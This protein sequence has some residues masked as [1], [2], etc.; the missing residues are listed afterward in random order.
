MKVSRKLWLGLLAGVATFDGERHSIRA[1]ATETQH[2][3][4]HGRRYWLHAAAYLS[5]RF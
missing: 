4:H 2:R 1:T 5:S 3:L